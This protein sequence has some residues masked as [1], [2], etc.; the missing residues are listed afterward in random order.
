MTGLYQKDE[1]I[2]SMTMEQKAI[3]S[4]KF[5]VQLCH[6]HPGKAAQIILNGIDAL[7]EKDLPE[8][9]II[10]CIED[11][12]QKRTYGPIRKIVELVA[13]YYKISIDDLLSLRRHK[14]VIIPRQVAMYLAR[15]CT[16]KTLP[17][18]GRAMGGKDHTTVLSGVRKISR[19][20]ERD[21][22]LAAD[23]SKLSKI[24][25]RQEAA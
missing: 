11:H 12:T 8:P 18:I 19:L 20:I 13:D 1:T 14:E 23:V 10:G 22:N 3:A 5:L 25:S 24:L 7:E 9:K 21:V 15:F 4:R 2:G 16:T 6:S 17:E